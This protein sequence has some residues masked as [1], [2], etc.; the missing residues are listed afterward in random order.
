MKIW[1]RGHQVSLNYRMLLLLVE[2]IAGAAERLRLRFRHC[3]FGRG[4]WE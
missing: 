4:L 1:S 3:F 2:A